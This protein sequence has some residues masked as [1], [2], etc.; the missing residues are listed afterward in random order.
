MARGLPAPGLRLSEGVVALVGGMLLLSARR[1][2]TWTA[3]DW[4]ALLYAAATLAMGGWDLL[5]RGVPF[6]Q[7]LVGPLLGPF[8][9]LLLYRAIAVTATTPE[10]RRTA[11]RCLLLASIPVAVLAIGQQF[12]APGFRSLVV[13]LTGND[14]FGSDGTRTIRATGPFPHWHNLGGYLLV[15]LL[16]N[17]ALLIRRVDGVLPRWGLLSVAALNAIALL[18]TVSIAPIISAIAGALILGVWFGGLGRMVLTLAIGA[19]VAAGLF[20]PTF[21]ARFNEQ[22]Q[23]A[24]GVER[25]A[26]VPQTVQY[27]YDLWTTQLLPELDG[28]WLTGYGPDLPPAVR[29]FPYTE[30]LYL[31]LLFRGGV[32][33]LLAW[34]ALTAA[35]AWAGFRST[36]DR[37]PLQQA[38]GASVAVA[39]FVLIFIQVF[40]AYFFDAGCP[41]ALW[42][43]IGLLA[44][45]EVDDRPVGGPG[46]E[47]DAMQ[48]AAA[49]RR[50][51]AALETF[52][53][54][55]RA[56]L[57]LSYSHQVPDEDVVDV[58]GVDFA[59]MR[60]WRAVALGRLST[61]TRLPE[62]HVR[63]ILE[64]ER[65]R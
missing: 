45:R 4:T 58:V 60:S 35:M 9:F 42:A 6:S 34:V 16:V 39:I 56:L 30:S 25:S 37:D 8:Q 5:Q 64:S 20:A 61:L 15:L 63:A 43:A 31:G 50:V 48:R 32:V 44:F 23:R 59:T 11:L 38:L 7:D 51:R 29:N 40:Q 41:H 1:R 49:G 27:R 18:A 17:M 13:T 21:E 10:R 22:F 46:A 47:I 36:R 53:P 24:P 19:L 14:I 3:L 57:Q 62:G 28:R 54:G 26:F 55:T 33:L 65:S 12:D 52:D 2:V